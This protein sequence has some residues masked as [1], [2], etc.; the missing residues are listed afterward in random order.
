MIS[1]LI[2]D[3]KP[4]LAKALQQSLSTI[5]DFEPSELAYSGEQALD[6]LARTSTQVLARNQMPDL[7]LMDVQMPGIGGIE[8][9]KQLKAKYPHIKVLMISVHDGVEELQ[10]AIRAGAS[11]Y[12]LK[13]EST[14]TIAQAIREALEGGAPMSRSMGQKALQIIRQSDHRA[15]PIDN[16][17]LTPRELE[18]LEQ[19]SV[20]M[21][22]E[23]VASTLFISSGT[24]RKHVQN[25]YEK[26]CVHSKLEAVNEGRRRGLLPS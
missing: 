7:V 9:T 15:V 11:G 12:V 17:G 3:D 5:P 21:T 4:M 8:T 20:G 10:D 16:P 26:L 25:L 2:V 22:Y 23:E 24:V 13:D 18:L 19:L 1:L 6:Y 14:Q